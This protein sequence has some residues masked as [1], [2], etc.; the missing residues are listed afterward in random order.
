MC[1]NRGGASCPKQGSHSLIWRS[2]LELL[3]LSTHSGGDGS[4]SRLKARLSRW[5]CLII[6]LEMMRQPL[7]LLIWQTLNDGLST[8]NSFRLTQHPYLYVIALLLPPRCLWDRYSVILQHFFF[9]LLPLCLWSF[10][11][12]FFFLISPGSLSV[13]LL[14]PVPRASTMV[15]HCVIY[16]LHYLYCPPFS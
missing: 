3:C 14:H 16:L 9:F 8:K 5:I 11:V 15:Y 10:I 1:V 4:Y 6:L 2:G 13:T 7:C 12:S